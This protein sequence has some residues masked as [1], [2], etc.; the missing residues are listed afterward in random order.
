MI[1]WLVFFVAAVAS[2]AAPAQAAWHKAESP[3]FV[4]YAD[5]DARSVTRFAETLERFHS[6]MAIVTNRQDEA[7]SPS[8]RVTI[9]VVGSDSRLRQLAGDKSGTI[10][11]FYM[12]RASG[13]VAFVPNIQLGGSETDFSLVVLLH[14]YAHHFLL[15]TNRFAMPRWIDE[16]MAEFFASA[17]FGRDGSVGIGRPAYHRAYELAAAVDVTVEELIDH[18]VYAKRRSKSYDAF[19]GRSWALFHYLKFEDLE[20]KPRKGQLVTYARA[21]A[22]GK[23]SR[24]AAIEA[25]GDLKQLERDLDSYQ[26]R[27]RITSFQFTPEHIPAPRVTTT[28]LSAG[29]A[30]VMPMRIRSQRG[31]S[32]EQAL[33]LVPDV[34]KVA[35]KFPQDGPVWAALAEAEYDAGNHEAAIAAADKAIAADPKLV[36]AHVQK[37]CALF[38][39][40]DSAEPDEQPAAYRRAMAPFNALNALENDHPLPLIYFYRSFVDQGREPNEL[41]RHALERASQ[42]APFDRGLAFQVA[43]MQAE[44]G[45]IGIAKLGFETLA[46]D[47]HGG[48]LAET[49]RKHATAIASL[50][51]GTRWQ[52][53]PNLEVSDDSETA[54]GASEAN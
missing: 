27:S 7:P 43:M 1:K 36:N 53:P 47:P 50:A 16:G 3:H 5:A 39:L 9:F 6:A 51:E 42:L 2:V 48:S 37:G 52:V 11:G 32:R 4:I 38:A 22:G 17:K 30:A 15:S 14:E 12:P 21:I 24:D 41:A 20:Q 18:E 33:A 26:R 13:S 54:D 34:R 44:E 46:A 25:F 8:G 35:A 23:S 19:Y 49:A 29:E 28:A 10:A 40:A 45:K 31:V